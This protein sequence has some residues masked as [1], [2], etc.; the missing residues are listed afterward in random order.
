MSEEEHRRTVE[1]GYD[2][3]AG[4]YLATKDP[5]DPL[6]LAASKIWPATSRP[7][8]PCSIWAA[9]PACPSRA[10]SQAEDSP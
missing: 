8:P 5:E 1:R 7:G 3:I 9:A 2:R 4:Q 6:T 10:G